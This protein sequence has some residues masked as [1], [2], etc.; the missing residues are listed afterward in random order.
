MSNSS[1]LG[2]NPEF[3]LVFSHVSLFN[4]FPSN[5]SDFFFSSHWIE[6]GGRESHVINPHNYSR[7]LKPVLRREFQ[8]TRLLFQ[9]RC[10]ARASP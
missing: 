9:I 7:G 10:I 6:V 2:K 5:M 8:K 4:T 3:L 1:L